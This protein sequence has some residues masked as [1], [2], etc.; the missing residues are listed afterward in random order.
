MGWY[1]YFSFGSTEYLPVPKTLAHGAEDL[2]WQQFDI[3]VVNELCSCR[4]QQGALAVSLWTS[5]LGVLRENCLI[6]REFLLL[7]PLCLFSFCF[8]SAGMELGA[9]G[10]PGERSTTE[11]H[12]GIY[13]GRDYLILHYGGVELRFHH[14]QC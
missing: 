9:L 2:C 7:L 14:P 6:T 1:L 3:S 10:M 8:P 13:K 5:V 4:L 11:L 12:P